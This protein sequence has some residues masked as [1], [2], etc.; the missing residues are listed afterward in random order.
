MGGIASKL[1]QYRSVVQEVQQEPFQFQHRPKAPLGSQTE[2]WRIGGVHWI[3]FREIEVDCHR[4]PDDH[5]II[6]ESRDS[7][8]WIQLKILRRLQ[9]I[10]I[11]LDQFVWLM[12]FVKHPHTSHRSRSGISIEL[13]HY[14]S[15]VKKV[16]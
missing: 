10:G 9:F 4:F 14:S 1:G 7:R 5:A 8:V 11:L 12:Y 16:Q 3:F 15:S 13:D 6:N 2:C